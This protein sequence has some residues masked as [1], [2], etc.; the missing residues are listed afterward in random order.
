MKGKS[1]LR[2]FLKLAIIVIPLVFIIF[3]FGEANADTTIGVK[4]W[5]AQWSCK[6]YFFATPQPSTV[7]IGYSYTNKS[8]AFSSYGISLA[9]EFLPKLSMSAF[10]VLGSSHLKFR[11][12]D[13]GGNQAPEYDFNVEM[14]RSDLD[15]SLQ[16]HILPYLAL[17][18]GYKY[19]EFKYLYSD[20]SDEYHG[21]DGAGIG[22]SGGYP[23]E[24][25]LVAYGSLGII[26]KYNGEFLG[27]DAKYGYN[28]EAGLLYS[29]EKIHLAAHLAYRAQVVK[30]K[31]N[32]ADDKFSGLVL[33]V[34]YRFGNL[35]TR[36]SKGCLNLLHR[37][38]NIQG[39][40]S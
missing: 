30:Y 28:Y 37:M 9:H 27:V 22:V 39:F 12:F 19:V 17:F 11:F 16:Y 34:G 32:F 26:P 6:D 15:L 38:T 40:E 14:R 13:S 31:R 18:V 36:I 4:Y 24:W 23:I 29:I 21:F 3:I 10:F 8:P 25:G 33:G 20:G 35:L 7:F 5:Y 2:F 1:R